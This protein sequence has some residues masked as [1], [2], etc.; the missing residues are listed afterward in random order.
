MSTAGGPVKEGTSVTEI[1]TSS[2]SPR[3]NTAT[4][5]DSPSSGSPGSDSTFSSG[6]TISF[7]SGV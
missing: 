1:V 7:N 4:T 3:A 2:P 5:D 6:T